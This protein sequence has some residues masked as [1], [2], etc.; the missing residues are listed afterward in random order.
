MTTVTTRQMLRQHKAVFQHVKTTRQPAVVL[1]EDE[2][3][4]AIVSLGDLET[5]HQLRL[6]HSAR[7]LQTTAQR[8]RELLH[9][10]RLPRD[11]AARHD[12]Y[13]WEG[14]ERP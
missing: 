11:L 2:P 12:V 6:T 13:A 8:V 9:D 4:V 10:E 3:Q 1:S 5:L 14:T 7:A